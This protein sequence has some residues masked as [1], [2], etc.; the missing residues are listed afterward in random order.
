MI[1]L[2]NSKG[3]RR[4]VRA[5]GVDKISG[6]I[7]AISFEGIK[8]KFSQDTQEV[9]EKATNRPKGS[10]HLLIGAEVA[11]Y[12]PSKLEAVGNLVVLESEF[13]SGYSIFGTD[14]DLEASG[15]TLT[16]EVQLITVG[17]I[18][19]ESD[20]SGNKQDFSQSGER[21]HGS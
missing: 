10:V 5:F 9:W 17:K 8:H 4:L 15:I 16:E 1:E 14:P 21:F 7:P 19:D 12:F 3:D 18:W 13:G 6:E 2:M 11:S 20:G